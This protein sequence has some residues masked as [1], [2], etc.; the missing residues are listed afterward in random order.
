MLC[1]APPPLTDDQLSAAL[2]GEADQV[3]LDHLER[4]PSCTARLEQARRAERALAGR[5]YR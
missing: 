4:C 1:S 2:D 5:L 3:V